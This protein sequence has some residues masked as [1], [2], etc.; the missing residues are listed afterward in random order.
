MLWVGYR[1]LQDQQSQLSYSWDGNAMTLDPVSTGNPGWAEFMTAYNQF[2]SE[3]GGIPLLNQTP[4]LTAD[5]VQK[6]LGDRWKAFAAARPKYDPD[7]R[8][9]NDYFRVLLAQTAPAAA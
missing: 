1:V 3:R 9:L 6:A 4:A 5:Q 2:S 7:G 8:L